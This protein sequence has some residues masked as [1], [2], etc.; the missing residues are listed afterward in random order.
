MKLH[1]LFDNMYKNNVKKL[2]KV[3]MRQGLEENPDLQNHDE[4]EGGKWQWT[5]EVGIMTG[6]PGTMACRLRPFTL[7]AQ[8]YVPV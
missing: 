8:G 4:G 7:A 6:V 2:S 3:C 5:R 1:I